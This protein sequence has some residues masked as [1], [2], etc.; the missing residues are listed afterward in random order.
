[1]NLLITNTIATANYNKNL[2]VGQMV[3]GTGMS[4]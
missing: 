1:M 3:E 2:I 4:R